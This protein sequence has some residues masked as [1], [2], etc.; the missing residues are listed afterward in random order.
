MSAIF[1]ETL[2]FQQRDGDDVALVVLGDEMYA[3]YETPEGYTAVYDHE[4]G[5]YCYADLDSGSFASTGR[6]V[7]AGP[8]PS[9]VQRHLHEATAVRNGRVKARHEAMVPPGEVAGGREKFLTFGPSGGLLPGRRL[10]SGTVTGLTILV[11]FPDT[12]A[13]V[14]MAEVDGLLNGSGYT[15][16]GNA[17]SVRGYFQT[18]STGRLDFG[19][20]V[21]GP[22]RMSRPRLAYANTEGLLVPEAIQLAV[23][24]GVD[25]SRFDSCDEGIVDSLCIMYAGQTEYK[26]DLWPHNFVHRKEYNGVRTELYIVTS[27][28]RRAEDLSIGTFCHEAGHMLCR[29][30]DLYDYGLAEREGDDFKSAG[31]GMYCVMGAGNHLDRGKTPAPISAYLRHLV[32]WTGT[33][34]DL[35]AGG[36]FEAKQGDYDT[37]LRYRTDLENEYFLV[38]NRSRAGFDTHLPS[39]GLAVYHCDIRGSNEF[40][41]GTREQHYQCAVLQADGH[42]DLEANA[43][44]GDGGDLF[45]RVEGTAV[46][47]STRPATRRWDGTESGL[48]ISDVSA[49][50]EVISFLVGE[51]G[52]AGA[53]VVGKSEPRVA[54]PDG[55]ANGVAD[56][57]TFDSPGTVRSMTFEADVTHPFAGDLRIVLLSP[58]GRR[59]VLHDR[60]RTG[61]NLHVELDSE[62]PSALAPMVG[63]PVAGPWLLRVTDF[64]QDDAGTLD[65]WRIE[66]TVGT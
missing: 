7:D 11:D 65:R 34:V 53:T 51:V 59:A 58:T 62:P 60:V 21:V 6:R 20:V 50:G 24:A 45:G 30:P 13:A 41:Q 15:G 25:L 2:R 40:Q 35:N 22:Y 49:P 56:T 10:S 44:Q 3:R 57:I 8:P 26:G 52:D 9:G 38:E 4:A 37:V 31:V 18:M 43:N 12:P 16:G 14:G 29:F 46:S 42:L 36:R 27:A 23:D 48:T 47:H 63:Q 5:A 33:E 54:I 39:S 66:I 1:G 55:D 61:R 64:S 17:G 19:N 28:G 32:G